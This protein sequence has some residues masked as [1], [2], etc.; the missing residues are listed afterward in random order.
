VSISTKPKEYQF[1]KIYIPKFSANYS[2]S[3]TEL[4][5]ARLTDEINSDSPVADAA[6]GVAKEGHAVGTIVLPHRHRRSSHDHEVASVNVGVS[7]GKHRG[8]TR[9]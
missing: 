3:A 7:K 9:V 1:S 5:L 4:I 8:V 6:R 2:S